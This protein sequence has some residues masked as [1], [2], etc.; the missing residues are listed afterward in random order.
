MKKYYNMDTDIRIHNVQI[1]IK[2]FLVNVLG[3]DNLKT[4]KDIL[5]LSIPQLKKKRKEII[6]NY[7]KEFIE[8][9]NKE[10]KGMYPQAEDIL[11]KR[12]TRQ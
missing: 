10:Y 1:G 12:I 9:Y 8:Y 4:N 6:T 5:T 3:K 11:Y 7:K 2:G